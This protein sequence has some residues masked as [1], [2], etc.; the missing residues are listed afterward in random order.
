MKNLDLRFTA[1]G[2]ALVVTLTAAAETV[3]AP[4]DASREERFANPPACA[5]ILPLHHGRPNDTAK[6]DAEL[7]ALKDEGFG[8]FAG[9]VNMNSNY[10]HDAA[11][12][13][14]Y[15]YTVEKAHAMG[16]SLWLYD[17]KGYPSCT[18]GGQTLEGHP[19][20]QA[21]AYLV[22]VT[23]EPGGARRVT[24]IRDGYIREG[25]HVS[26]SV[27]TFKYAYPNLLM[28][29]PTDRFVELTHEAY[30]RE[31]GPALKHIDS[32]FT[33]EPSLMTLWMRPM[34]ELCLPV[35][36]ELLAAYEAKFG[37]PLKDDVPAL[38]SGEPV[39]KTAEIRH[40][41]WSM[42][43]ERVAK[44]YTGRL[45]E[46]ASANGI[47]SGGHLLSEE[48]L[49]AH[50]PLYGDFFRVLRGLSAPGCDILTSVPE[51][52]PPVTPLLAGSAGELNGA[53]RVMSEA[54][55]HSQKYRKAGDKRPVVQVT[56]RQVV[57]SLNRQIW[58]G[59][60]TF[61]SY[62][63]W[64]AFSAAERRAINEEIGRT[65]TLASEG[66]SAAE[67]ALLYPA[68]AL[69]TGFEPQKVGAGGQLARGVESCFL[70]ALNA[71]FR[72]G[73]PFLVVD[74]ESLASA[75]VKD[76]AL[77]SGPLVW[78]TV[79]LPS[80]VTLPLG[81]ARKLAALQAA[82]GQVI[83]L[84]ERPV[85]S[86]RAFPDAEIASLAAKWTL[87][88]HGL[89]GYLPEAIAARHRPPLEVTRGPAEILR[90]AHRRTAKDGDV[91]FVANDSPDP[92]A[93][94]LRV[95]GDPEV[96]VW[97]PR[98]GLSH[99]VKGEIPLE[100]PPYAAVVLTTSAELRGRVVPGE[101]AKFRLESRPF[102]VPQEGSPSV[103]KGKYV[104]AS[105]RKLADGFTRA[106][107]ELTKGDVDTFAFV[108]HVYARSPFAPDA[109]GLTFTV[110][111][112][113][114]N[115][116]SARLGVFLA[117]KDGTNFYAST[118]LT[119]KKAGTYEVTC[120]FAEFGHHGSASQGRAAPLR[121]EDIRRI[122]IGYGGYFGRMGE[123]V[124][125]DVAAPTACVLTSGK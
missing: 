114:D 32:T 31:L 9:N 112:P 92:W 55:D 2:A 52:V 110:R 78:R 89:I 60:N 123:K 118:G 79:V 80:A 20:W 116:G 96:R 24:G 71:L 102:A 38:V 76:G 26:V 87:L 70:K 30:R 25:T 67:V 91:L 4:A 23:N 98:I 68:D 113:E 101:G 3:Y 45:T 6:A 18:A 10:L 1:A 104:K 8:G 115:P 29:E 72:K 12:W 63:R 50:V 109:K 84:G 36:D 49:V 46:W 106:E 105:V 74:A 62:Y 15:R 85:N 61:T 59:V 108:N 107:T 28:R 47:L 42:V 81:A 86:E 90:V 66:R 120:T 5:R 54:S 16:M 14:T 17:E 53:P 19:E 73:R 111:V 7:Q 51:T 65:I 75:E 39:G 13:R 34:P 103:S 124:V 56:A 37:H 97:N 117:L 35:S 99:A 44:N 58:G 93:G 83:A 77:V 40:R 125:F 21:R 33:D 88:P 122:N 95:A 43:A 94:A 22:S 119:L 121:P 27:S 69:M 48:N 64:G 11:S 100:L 57:G 41:Y 82:G